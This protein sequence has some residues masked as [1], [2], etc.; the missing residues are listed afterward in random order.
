[1]I[2]SDSE[3][4]FEAL[5]QTPS[6]RNLLGDVSAVV[7]CP[8]FVHRHVLSH[9]VI[10]ATFHT[11]EVPTVPAALTAFRRVAWGDLETFA[12]ARLTGLYFEWLNR[13]DIG[14]LPLF[15]R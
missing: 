2:E 5:Q 3:L 8:P 9:R 11:L 6:Y 12:F 4:P 13:H 10:Y 14:S 1:M 7:V 15:G